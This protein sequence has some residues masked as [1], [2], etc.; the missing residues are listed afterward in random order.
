MEATSH[1]HWMR[2]EN[3]DGEAQE[4]GG[5]EEACEGESQSKVQSEEGGEEIRYT[6][7]CQEDCQE[8]SQ[9]TSCQDR[10]QESHQEDCQEA[11]CC[12][13]QSWSEEICSDD[14]FRR[15][16]QTGGSSLRQEICEAIRG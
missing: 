16:T 13:T 12:C 9:E 3:I 5:E 14:Q 7:G 8:G 2:E 6:E 10:C 11:Q 1:I 4:E 15:Y